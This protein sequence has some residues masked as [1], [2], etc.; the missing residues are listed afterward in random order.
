MHRL[1]SLD[2]DTPDLA[3]PAIGTL[4]RPPTAR[5]NGGADSID[6]F[7]KNIAALAEH[8]PD[9]GYLL[10]ATP[11][12]AGAVRAVARDGSPTFRCRSLDG[13]REWF[14]KT[15][16][17]KVRAV[18]L[19]EALGGEG[20]NLLLP[21]LRTGAEADEWL[22]RTAAHTAVLAYE[23]EL[24]SLR[25]AMSLTD[26]SAALRDRR[27]ILLHGT[28]IGEAL[29]GFYSAHPGF[30]FPQKMLVFPEME[31]AGVAELRA[32]VEQACSRVTL[33]QNHLV[34]QAAAHS[35]NHSTRRPPAS[36]AILTVDPR[37][38]V[39]DAIAS[40]GAAAEASGLAVH[41][42]APDRP[43]RCHHLARL[44]AMVDA[45]RGLTLLLNTGWGPL[46]RYLPDAKAAVSWFLPSARLLRGITDGFTRSHHVFTATPA[47]VAQLR[48]FGVPDDRVSLLEV[49]ADDAV[50]FPAKADGRSRR[51]V[52]CVASNSDL[53]PRACGMGLESQA[54]LWERVCALAT[55]RVE[56]SIDALLAAAESESGV[57]LSDARSRDEFLALIR[58]RVLPTLAARASVRALR[59]ARGDFRVYGDGWTADD[60]T[61]GRFHSL[62]Q[63]AAERC[64][65]YRRSAVVLFP[66]FGADTVQGILEAALCG[67]Y[68]LFPL[69]AEP[70]ETLHP[71][72]AGVLK[73]A[74]VYP[75]SAALIG[76]IHLALA[77]PLHR[78]ETV[79][80]L[81][82]LIR[83]S[84]LWTHRFEAI[85]ARV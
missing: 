21:S 48:D 61:G 51:Q 68:P 38:V 30:E 31:G 76:A 55:R 81:G 8:D 11:P 85:L 43:D 69:P 57:T 23:P 47:Q 83:D 75:T 60:C 39:L 62:P 40:L 71:Q 63:S 53:H 16:M 64:A 18:A 72:L 33:L 74:P 3:A 13:S 46:R 32:S 15:S 84:H 4:V 35:A 27:L 82:Q 17:P 6:Y 5:G 2:H 58:M 77:D 34:M 28:S 26:F 29:E 12:P 1:S 10:V 52:A 65:V 66:V 80:R 42:C 49:A 20:G 36:L 44:Q 59:E 70:L 9:L 54:R 67:A 79:D 19:I 73:Q 24:S 50:F 22:R 78:A 41:V 7:D 25:L 56:L 45:D 14:G 37:P